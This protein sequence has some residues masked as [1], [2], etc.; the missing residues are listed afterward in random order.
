MKDIYIIFMNS[1]NESQTGLYVKMVEVL[2]YNEDHAKKL[3]L[4]WLNKNGHEYGGSPETWEVRILKPDEGI[5]DHEFSS[6]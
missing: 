2:A 5:I 3:A 6:N 1:E 4:N